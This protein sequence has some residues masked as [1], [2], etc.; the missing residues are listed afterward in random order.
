M[1]SDPMLMTANSN[2]YAFSEVLVRRAMWPEY[3]NT[4]HRLKEFMDSWCRCNNQDP[5]TP[6]IE[7]YIGGLSTA[8]QNAVDKPVMLVG[9]AHLRFWGYTTMKDKVPTWILCAS[10]ISIQYEAYE[11]YQKIISEGISIDLKPVLT[12]ILPF[13]SMPNVEADR[14]A[15]DYAFLN[16]ATSLCKTPSSVGSSSSQDKP[17]LNNTLNYLDRQANEPDRDYNED[18]NLDSLSTN[19]GNLPLAWEIDTS[20]FN[21][22]TTKI[23]TKPGLVNKQV[24]KKKPDRKVKPLRDCSQHFIVDDI[25][26]RKVL[27][28]RRC[29]PP[30]TQEEAL[31]I[32][33]FQ[34][35]F[36]EIRFGP[37]TGN[38][39]LMSLRMFCFTSIESSFDRMLS[40][41]SNSFQMQNHT[42]GIHP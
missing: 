13:H 26:Q 8:L 31:H 22:M 20:D 37:F 29:L 7:G 1:L 2:E 16:Q 11:S 12:S 39:T 4:V 3:V 9:L 14:E 41:H 10:G 36:E 42:P 40:A 15:N 32:L 21:T 38:T 23:K 34:P 33:G 27:D 30:L 25:K 6:K 35:P 18:T 28:L 5:V 24:S 17:A 19:L